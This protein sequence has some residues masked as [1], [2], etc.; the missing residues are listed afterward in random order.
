[1]IEFIDVS[2]QFNRKGVTTDALK[3]VSLKVEPGEI[4][5]IVGFSGAGKSTLI[6][7]VNRLES[8]TTGDVKI[9]GQSLEKSN[10]KE[11]RTIKRD[12]G[13][14][15]QHFN[16]LDS[17]TVY[18]NVA[19]PL[20]LQGVDKGEIDRRVTELLDFVGLGDKSKSYPDELSGGQKQRVGIARALATNPKILLCDEATSALDPETTTQILELLKEINQTYGITILLITHEMSVVREICDRVAIMEKGRVIEEGTVFDIFSNPKTDTGKSFVNTVMHNEVPEFVL[21]LLHE[22]PEE[23][24]IYRLNFV[25]DSAGEP[26]LSQVSKKF[27]VETS[28]LFGNIT[29]LQ[30][31]PFG[32]LIV[33]FIGQGREVASVLSYLDSRN[34][35]YSEVTRDAR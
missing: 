13:M 4:F 15:F 24:H 10:T 20:I 33:E 31:I 16:L 19:M 26:V 35:I 9:A 8:P 11:I 7:M 1:M 23:R 28:V 17:K 22:S 5:G 6:R 18:K 3:N 32:N 29:Q 14:I 25:D 27:D 34:I 21:K 12:I 30:D 2:K